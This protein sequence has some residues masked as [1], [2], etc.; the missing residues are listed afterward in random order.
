MTHSKSLQ[1]IKE[2]LMLA[3]QNNISYLAIPY[4]VTRAAQE[5]LALIPDVEA[6][7][8]GWRS[9]ES[10][11]KDGTEILWRSKSGSHAVIHWDTY[12]EC[13]EEEGSHWQLLP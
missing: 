3:A 8:N 6:G 13:Y 1:I 9:I 10:A 4:T 7:L 5:A 11:P 12:H 2:A